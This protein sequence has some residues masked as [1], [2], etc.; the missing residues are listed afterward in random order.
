MND[1]IVTDEQRKAF[2]EWRAERDRQERLAMVKVQ[3]S[4]VPLRR[5]RPPED[6]CPPPLPDE[7]YANDPRMEEAAPAQA[8]AEAPKGRVTTLADELIPAEDISAVTDRPY[9]IKGWLDRGALSVIYGESNVGKTFLALDL[10]FHIA[11]GHAWHGHRAGPAGRVIYVAAEGGGG[12]RNRIEAI[13]R[14]HPEMMKATAG[15]F[16]LLPAALDLHGKTDAA[17]LIEVA[18]QGEA[19]SLIVIDT[20]AR[21]MGDGDGKP[22]ARPPACG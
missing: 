11:A 6:D 9:L 3:A 1:M 14:E 16:Q 12:I 8:P 5:S 21:A 7:A 15:R 4:E 22:V 13:K 2:A 19:V 17:A 18:K 10:G 20:L